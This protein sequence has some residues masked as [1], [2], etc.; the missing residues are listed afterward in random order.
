MDVGTI[1]QELSTAGAIAQDY[2]AGGLQ[3]QLKTNYSPA[4][5]LYNQLGQPSAMASLLGLQGGVRVLDAAGNV[6]AQI[7]DW[8]A[9]DPV[10]VTLALGVL[11]FLTLGL[12]KALRGRR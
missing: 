5:T 10:R 7:G 11:G 12:V 8:P 6:V 4:V 2:S 3:L 9:T 1:L